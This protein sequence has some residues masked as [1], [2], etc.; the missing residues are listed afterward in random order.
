MVGLSLLFGLTLPAAAAERRDTLFGDV[1]RAYVQDPIAGRD[2]LLAFA[3]DASSGSSPLLRMLVADAYVRA[4]RLGTA[5]GMLRELAADR[6]GSPWTELSLLAVAWLDL[7]SGDFARARTRYEQSASFGAALVPVALGFIDAAEGRTDA[8]IAGLRA[9]AT[10]PTIAPQLRPVARI[11]VA[12]ARYWA[13]DYEGAAM[14][15]QRV[16]LDVADSPVADDAA[17]GAAWSRWRAGDPG[18]VDALHALAARTPHAV[19]SERIPRSVTTLRARALVHA[20]LRRYRRGR[21]VLPP[22][23][24]LVLLDADGGALARTALTFLEPDAPAPVEM[25]TGVAPEIAALDATAAR[26]RGEDRGPERVMDVGPAHSA[27][28][29]DVPPSRPERAAP[30][31]YPP[32]A[33]T[34]RAEQHTRSL[35]AGLVLILGGVALAGWLANRRSRA[36]GVSPPRRSAPP[37]PEAPR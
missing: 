22:D 4:G 13:R 36:S 10:A 15:F 23:Q 11:G 20:G 35:F 16:A 8:A 32:A 3:G 24:L 12:Y 21:P 30:A 19:P 1:I 34:T 9:A 28:V 25:A 31:E 2:A 14:E 5:Q 27:P 7:A 17:Y 18:A 37:R 33:T 26:V 6:P 29:T